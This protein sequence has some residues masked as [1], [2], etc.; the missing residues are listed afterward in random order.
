MG[1]RSA[2]PPPPPPDYL[3]L[4]RQQ[5]AENQ[6]NLTSQTWANRPTIE[7]PWGSQTWETNEAIDPATG[8]RVT[9]W[10]GRL[11]LSPQQQAA[12]DSQMA[13]QMGLSNQAETF[14]GR[15]RDS[16]SQPFDWSNL[17]AAAQGVQAQ[18]T[19]PAPQALGF[20]QDPGSIA[21]SFAGGGPITSRIRG[22]GPLMNQINAG[23]S[24]VDQIAGAGPVTTSI[25]DAGPLMNRIGG[26]ADYSSRAGDALYQQALSRLDPRFSQQASDLEA[27]LVNRGIAR[28]SEAW[29]REM[30]NFERAR[31]DA[32]NQ[33]AFSAAQLAGQEAARLQ[34]MDVNA[35]NFWNQAQQQLFS[36]NAAQAAFANQAQQQLFGQNA[37]QAAFT[38][39]AQQQRFGQAAQQ[40]DLWNRAQQQLFGQNA[41][42]AAFANQ[43]QQQRFGQNAA[44]AEFINQAQAQQFG[45]NQAMADFYNRALQQNFGNQL[46]A[47]QQNFQQML[48]EQEFQQRLRQQ[49]IAEQQAARAQPLNE[50]NAL[51]TG[52]QVGT[53]QMPS[54]NTA[55]LAQTPNLL[56]AADMGYQAQLGQY[57]AMLANQQAQRQGL[58]GALGT[59]ANI[60][61]LFRLSDRRLKSKIKRIGETAR[62]TPLYIYEMGGRTQI[63]VIAQEA[64]AHAVVNIGGL[65]AVDYNE[66]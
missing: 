18:L 41:Q 58:F 42:Q 39:Q 4:A 25:S 6:Q 32:Y 61:G 64:P 66:V 65:L 60:A 30:G 10:T 23:G 27:S 35:G 11:N 48:Q 52:Q 16:M 44:L 8:Q 49:A 34:G 22:A 62:G 3:G 47:N 40:A 50:L 29:N 20:I 63:G 59:A 14:L 31:N 15:V 54:F 33:A 53:P 51:L 7:T 57:N 26:S 5:A 45:Q 24:I 43:A 55:G 19:G 46:T 37:A 2:P 12:L 28:G 17:P 56:G 21:R 1:R 13:V 9:Q 36:Q 38:N